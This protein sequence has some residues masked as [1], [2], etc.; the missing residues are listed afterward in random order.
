MSIT[1]NQ[2][3]V[4]ALREFM[5][6]VSRSEGGMVRTQA[7]QSAIIDVGRPDEDLIE[8]P[9]VRENE[10]YN[11]GVIAGSLGLMDYLVDKGYSIID[12]AGIKVERA[13]NKSFL[14]TFSEK[15]WLNVATGETDDAP[16]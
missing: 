11:Y 5:W 4:P 8:N 14:E 2:P 9:T 1:L 3:L 10:A 7:D 16:F 12:P 15:N 13:E 6:D